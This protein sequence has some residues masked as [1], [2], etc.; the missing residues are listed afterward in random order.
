MGAVARFSLGNA[1]TS[2]LGVGYPYG[3]LVINII[4]SFFVGICFE[5]L[6]EEAILPPVW[7]SMLMV[8]F[9]GAFTTFSTF[10]VQVLGLFEAGR[11]LAALSYV[12]LSV[13]LSV[14]AVAV[15]IFIVR[16][17]TT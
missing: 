3:I 8:G 4:G 16:Q 6:V 2:L 11:P 9:L 15:G 10:S 5:L 12:L 1:I 17:L 13:V 7:R 14:L